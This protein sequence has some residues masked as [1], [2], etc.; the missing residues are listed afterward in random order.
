MWKD[1]LKTYLNQNANLKPMVVGV[2]G[3]VLSSEEAALF[4]QI[5][6][7]GWIL[8]RSNCKN[9][10]QVRALIESLKNTVH[11]QNPP[12]LIDQEGGRVQRLHPPAWAAYPALGALKESTQGNPYRDF[13]DHGASIGAELFDLGI[14]FNCAPC[15]DLLFRDADSI[16]A[17]R[18]AGAS[19]EIAVPRLQAW[20]EGLLSC[21]VLPILKHVPGHGRALVDSHTACPRIASSRSTLESSD[22]EVFRAM[23]QWWRAQHH[24]LEDPWMMTGHLIFESID[25]RRPTTHSPTVIREVIREFIGLRGILV[26]DW[27]GM[28]ALSGSI[29]ERAEASWNAGCDVVLCCEEE[30]LEAIAAVAP[31][32]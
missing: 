4:R 13:F 3:S 18:S 10:D 11:H 14:T 26:T 9:P 25:P 21:N 8:F 1:R 17:D 19:P 15:C 28:N 23:L 16:I 7:L 27:I 24:T 31:K 32:A 30:D 5:Q 22:F 20:I 6:P 29:V 12:I 2:R